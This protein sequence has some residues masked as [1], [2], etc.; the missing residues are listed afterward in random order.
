MEETPIYILENPFKKDGIVQLSIKHIKK[1]WFCGYV[2]FNN[3]S[4]LYKALEIE[5]K[6]K[7]LYG[8]DYE[9]ETMIGANVHGSITYSAWNEE[10]NTIVI[11]F[12]CNHLIDEKYPKPKSYCTRETFRLATDVAKFN[13]LKYIQ[14]CIIQKEVELMRYKEKC[15]NT[16]PLLEKLV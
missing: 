10:K 2:E 15:L 1:Q 5:F 4:E 8:K 16:F 12:D 14:N 6:D 7:S 3:K 11:G 9:I 13:S